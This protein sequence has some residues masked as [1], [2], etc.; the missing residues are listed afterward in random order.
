MDADILEGTTER[1]TVIAHRYLS[2]NLMNGALKATE[3]E[4]LLETVNELTDYLEMD[5]KGLKEWGDEDDPEV[6]YPKF[7][8]SV[9]A[10][11]DMFKGDGGYRRLCCVTPFVLGIAM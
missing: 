3:E 2:R 4:K 10:K 9:Q 6:L 1:E 8:A 7:S 5:M 11:A